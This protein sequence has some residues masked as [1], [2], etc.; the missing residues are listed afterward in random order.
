MALLSLLT[1]T[2]WP[3][4]D[5]RVQTNGPLSQ[6]SDDQAQVLARLLRENRYVVSVIDGRLSG[7]GKDFLMQASAHSQF[8]ALGEE[9]NVKEVPEFTSMLFQ[10]LHDAYGYNYLALEQDPLMMSVVSRP[11]VRGD[12]AAALDL[13]RKYP[14]GY[15]FNTD[16]EV[17]MIVSAGRM[18][19]AKTDPIWGL[20]QMFGA[21]HALER[22]LPYAP[23]DDVR[24]RTRKLIQIAREYDA[25][26]F[27]P[28]R[29]YMAEID[30]PE[31]LWNLM[32]LY[33]PAA[34][35]EAEFI[36]QQLILSA[37]IYG[38]Y[39]AGTEKRIPGYFENGRV[40]EQNMKSLFMANYRKALGAGDHVPKVLLKFGHWHL[41]RGMSP[42]NV[43][44]LGN[45]V[46]ELATSNGFASFHLAIAIHNPPDGFRPISKRL[47][48]KPLAD[49]ADID[50]WT[51]FDLQ[52]LRDYLHAGFIKVDP[53]FK[54]LIY[55]FDG[56]MLI[57]GGSAA[58][59][60]LVKTRLQ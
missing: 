53:E 45:F 18:S 16:Q 10:A 51:I 34:G 21:Q 50:R 46:S 32:Q 29:H 55:G 39:K 58:T 4:A 56:V 14:N 54:Q 11:P 47:P 44:S 36:I 31:D 1:L 49:A 9:H 20:D 41:Y 40:R 15:T 37:R 2:E 5:A 17:N 25:V 19:A 28:G 8:F 52:P 27:T 42:G 57:G 6:A 7:P 33:H 12:R 60:E 26:R 48:L 24:D 43:P 22:I 30:K 13:A 35:S 23:N 59:T 3:Q 38:F